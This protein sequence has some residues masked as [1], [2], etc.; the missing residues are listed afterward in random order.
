MES[1]LIFFIMTAFMKIAYA[2]P[3]ASWYLDKLGSS[4]YALYTG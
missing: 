1:I 3:V 4:N 2:S